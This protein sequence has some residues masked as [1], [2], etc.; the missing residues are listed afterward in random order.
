MHTYTR[1]DFDSSPMIVFYEMTRACDLACVHCRADAQPACDPNELSPAEARRLVDQLLS[2]ARPPMLVLTGGDPLKRKDVFD[3]VGYATAGNLP[4]AMTPSATPL[5]TREAI[6]R[7][8]RS[9][10]HRLAV[11]LDAADARTHDAFRGVPG[12]FRRTLE[13]IA[14]AH[15][16]GLPVQINTTVG[17][18]NVDQIDQMLE[19]AAELRAVLWSVFFIVPTGRAG[20]DLRLDAEQCE[21]VF[22]RLWLGSQ[23]LG[24]PIKTTEAPHYRRFILQQQRR[25]R[26]AAGDG[27]LSD[28]AA[29]A[30]RSRGIGP[31][32]IG[33]NDGKGIMFISHIGEIFPSGFLPICC[34]RFP[35]DSVVDVYQNAATFRALR[36][37][38]GL[39]GKCGACEYRELCGGS[40]ARAY[41]IYGDPLAAEPD[42]AYIPPR[43]RAES[44]GPQGGSSSQRQFADQTGEIPTA[45]AATH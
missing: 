8:H 44:D 2:F 14:D 35:L 20:A 32:Q 3:L 12:S 31:G 37:A 30:A 29:G 23:R 28:T 13:I 17:R 10:L 34:G 16:V 26:S 15:A 6:A 7:L 11:S 39:G 40:R 42:C 36:D 43:F 25:L 19:L 33:T 24:L 4:V 41:A 1:H 45:G 27:A 21:Q 5:V 18:H 38:S 22:Q 9:G